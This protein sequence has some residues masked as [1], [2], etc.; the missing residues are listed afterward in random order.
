GEL[1]T[2]V[3]LASC[4]S[5]NEAHAAAAGWGGDAFTVV[6]SAGGLG[7]LWSTVWDDEESA[8]RFE[9]ALRRVPACWP[10]ASK[11]GRWSVAP[12]WAVARRGAEVTLVRGLDG[13]EARAEA[14]WGSA[15][16]K[17]ASL[18]PLGKVER[19]APIADVGPGGYIDD[20]RWTDDRLG[21]RADV[22]AGF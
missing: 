18:P 11:A 6:R 2:R 19:P 13:P 15:G 9:A 22:P 3:L 10:D 4:M 7:L 14:L 12:G 1:G 5:Q 8:A 17:V 16:T 21:L 20:A